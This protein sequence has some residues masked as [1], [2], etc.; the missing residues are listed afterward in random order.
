VLLYVLDDLIQGR[1]DCWGCKH[2]GS[3]SWACR[4]SPSKLFSELPYI[5][6]KSFQE[7]V[8]NKPM[9]HKQ[10]CKHKTG[11]QKPQKGY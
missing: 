1:M 7:V 10:G 11:L 9:L 6:S 4:N 5:V 2:A 8:L 3:I